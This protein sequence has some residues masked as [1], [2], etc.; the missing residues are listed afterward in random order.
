MPEART[1]RQHRKG[2]ERDVEP[3]SAVPA[4]CTHEQ[5]R[6][7]GG[8]RHAVRTLLDRIGPKVDRPDLRVLDSEESDEVI[9]GPLLVCDHRARRGDGQTLPPQRI[10]LS[11]VKHGPHVQRCALQ[12]SRPCRMHEMHP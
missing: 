7:F 4:Q 1:T 5:E 10:M 2:I 8:M 3:L 9:P 11:E 6:W 12:L